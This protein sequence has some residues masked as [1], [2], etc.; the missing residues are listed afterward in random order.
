MTEV[1]GIPYPQ[2][3]ICKIQDEV[4]YIVED[5]VEILKEFAEM[6]EWHGCATKCFANPLDFLREDPATLNGCVILDVMLPGSDGTE[7]QAWLKENAPHIPVIIVSGVASLRTAIDCMRK[8]AADF[9]SKP[10]DQSDL[11]PALHRAVGLSR[12]A[13]CRRASVMEVTHRLQVLTPAEQ[14][15]AEYVAKGYPSKKIANLIGRSVNTVKIHKTRIF[16]KLNISS[17]VSLHI[18]FRFI[19]SNFS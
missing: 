12:M 15:I 17:S 18:L 1:V 7:I 9:L 3:P 13:H 14:R 6:I 19:D 16:Y 4:V 8:G 10:I 11:R 2:N 5:N